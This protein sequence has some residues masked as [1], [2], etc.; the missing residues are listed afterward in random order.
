VLA[1]RRRGAEVD[2]IRVEPVDDSVQIRFV[3]F[4]GNALQDIV[5]AAVEDDST[6]VLSLLPIFQ[7]LQELA[8]RAAVFVGTVHV[9]LPGP[10]VRDRIANAK[11]S[12]VR[13]R[14]KNKG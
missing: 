3:L 10:S 6:P 9:G 13:R 1:P 11:N 5:D 2:T 8:R 12:G 4:D 14:A 7:A